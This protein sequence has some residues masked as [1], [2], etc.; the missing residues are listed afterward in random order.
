VKYT[1]VLTFLFAFG[2]RCHFSFA[3]VSGDSINVKAITAQEAARELVNPNSPLGRLT[4]QFKRWAFDRNTS[5]ASHTT[6]H[7]ITLESSIPF[8]LNTGALIRFRPAIP[9]FLMYPVREATSQ[10]VE[11][12]SGLGD[13]TF[14]LAY[15][16]RNAMNGRL[17][18]MAHSIE[19]LLN[20]LLPCCLATAGV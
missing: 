15:G 14:D 3:Q 4:L 10:H 5:E 1:L 20:R 8:Q 6:G 19:Q 2:G 17:L 18:V 7:S 16:K 12:R 9:V 13:I 11:S